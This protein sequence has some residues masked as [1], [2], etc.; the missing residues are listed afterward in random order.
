MNEMLTLKMA[1]VVIG[2][3]C[4]GANNKNILYA[5]WMFCALYLLSL[6]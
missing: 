2:A 4:Y 6:A 5:A 1:A 3:I